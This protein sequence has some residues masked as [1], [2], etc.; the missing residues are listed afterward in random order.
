MNLQLTPTDWI[1]LACFAAAW[2][3]YPWYAQWH[4]RSTPS[5]NALINVYRHQWMH[6]VLGREGRIVDSSILANLSNSATFFSSTTILILGGLLAL[7]D[8]AAPMLA[9]LGKI[10]YAQ[11]MTAEIWEI[12]IILMLLIFTYAFFKFTW[13]LRQFNFVSILVGATP[14]REGETAQQDELA[15][16]AGRI[17]EHA[18]DSFSEGLRAYYFALAALTWFV[19]PALFVLGTVWVVAILYY[20]EFRSDTV[21]ALL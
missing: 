5:L 20:L 1:A 13:S 12:K 3:G 10:P 11:R 8:N 16:R 21:R 17:L 18:G 4:A 7:I 6:Q 15:T 14:A 19:H 2:W 9:A